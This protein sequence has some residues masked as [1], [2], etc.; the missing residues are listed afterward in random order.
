MKVRAS[1][2]KICKKC[3]VDP[4]RRASSGCSARTRATSSG[5]AEERRTTW[6]ASQASTCRATSG[7][8]SRSPTSTASA[9][10]RRAAILRRGRGRPEHARR[11]DADRRRGRAHPPRHRRE[12]QGR[13]RS[14]PRGRAEHQAPDGPRLLPRPAPPPEPAGARPAHAHQRAH[15]QGPAASDRRQEAGAVQ[16]LSSESGMARSDRWRSEPKR[17]REGDSRRREADGAARRKKAQARSVSEGVAHIHSTFNNTIVTITDPQ[18]QRRRPG[19]APA[20]SAS[21]A[22][23]RGRRSPRSSRPRPPPRKAMELGMRQRAG[24]T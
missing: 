11:D 4:P 2:K 18:G 6:H 7:W 23:A 3:K 20:R 24:A 15:P 16:G 19:R 17:R 22:R 10:A 12:L 8:R 21:R 14:A 5:K 13:G 1:V 9:G